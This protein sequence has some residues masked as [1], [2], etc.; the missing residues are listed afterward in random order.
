MEQ[1]KQVESKIP[2]PTGKGG[3]G[4]NPNNINLN[5]RPRKG[6]AWKDV[7]I[8]IGD[9]EALAGSGKTRKEVIVSKVYD[10]AYK[11]NMD[12]VKLL[13]NSLVGNKNVNEVSGR[14]GEDLELIIRDYRST[15]GTDS[16]TETK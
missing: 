4:D 3:F 15:G 9:E 2:N 6:M 5:G 10:E 13:W 11:G 7:V 14:D 12:A 1:D 16:T 8:D